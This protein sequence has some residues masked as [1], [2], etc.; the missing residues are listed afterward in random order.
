MIRL[1]QAFAVLVSIAAVRPASENWAEFRGPAGAGHSD[2]KGLPR[3]WSETKNVVWKTALHGRGWSSPVVWGAQV[4][5]TTGTPDGKELSVICVDRESGKVLLDHKLFIVAKPDELWRKFNS[6]ASPTPALEEGFAYVHFGTYGTACI[7]TKTLKAVWT[8]ED[9]QCNHWR[10]AGSS[11]IL[12]ENLLILTFDGYDVQYLVALDKK[13]GKTVWKSDRSHDFGTDD[14]DRK[15]GY[16]TPIIIEAAG[17]HQ[18]ITPASSAAVSLDP[19]TGKVLWFIKYGGHSPAMRSLYGD[20]LVYVTSG[21]G[22]ELIAIKPDG[23]G[24]VTKT[25]IAWKTNKG[26]G[27]KPSPVLVDGL[28][29]VVSDDGAAVCIEAKTGQQVWTQRI[30]KRQF[31]ASPLY[32]DG[33]IYFF[34]EDGSA[35]VIQPGRE[36]KE[37]AR[38]KLDGGSECKSTPA[39]AG[40]SFFIRTD[41]NLYRIEA[42]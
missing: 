15:K 28:L 4:W 34:A 39:I 12:F 37:I 35:C 20:G 42:K 22:K 25:H 3:E 8:R 26:I 38:S 9:L 30:E 36:Y 27:H 11:P 32:A 10:G 18:L 1:I 31:S 19:H 5:L 23:S 17:K 2:A 40:K 6:Y 13:T 21:A 24:D 29:Y 7:D 33:V 14:G 16:S 41:S